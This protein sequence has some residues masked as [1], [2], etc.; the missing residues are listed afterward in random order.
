MQYSEWYLLFF[1]FFFPLFI[2]ANTHTHKWNSHLN[3]DFMYLFWDQSKWLRSPCNIL[4]RE[5]LMKILNYS[6]VLWHTLH[7]NNWVCEQTG[8]HC[9][10][11]L[12]SLT[13]MSLNT[14]AALH[15]VSLL[16]ILMISTWQPRNIIT[17]PSPLPLFYM[18][19]KWDLSFSILQA[20]QYHEHEA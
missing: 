7:C 8:C 10:A 15:I 11:V 5:T 6:N 3:W 13:K 2:P 16:L 14:S 17:L 9:I 4:K 19:E 18:K 12:L 1:F 20:S